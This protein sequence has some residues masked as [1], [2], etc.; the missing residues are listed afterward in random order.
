MRIANSVLTKSKSAK[1][2]LTNRPE[3]LLSV[4]DKTKLFVDIFS[5]NSN[6]DCLAV[7]P[8]KTYLK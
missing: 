4:S 8:S 3:V 1:S 5:E 2:P 7:L 6:L